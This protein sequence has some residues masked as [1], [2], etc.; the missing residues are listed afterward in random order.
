[1]RHHHPHP[2]TN[3]DVDLRRFRMRDPGPGAFGAFGPGARPGGRG[4]R[5]FGPG[6]DPAPDEPLQQGHHGGTGHHD[7]RG[8]GFGGPRGRGRAGRGD[9]RAA[10]LL[11]LAEQPMHGYQLIQEIAQRSED[12]WRPS[13]GAVYPALAM[14]EDEGLVTLSAEGGRRLARLTDAGAAYVEENAATLGVPW[15]DAAERPVNPARALRGAL[16]ALSAAAVQVART[17]T[18]QQ[19]EQALAVIE[20]ARRDLYLLLAG[21]APVAASAPAAQPDVDPAQGVG[22]TADVDEEPTA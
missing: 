12:R 10:V 4:P 5:G 13:P 19:A 8:R 18:P 1:M 2:R 16:E 15:Q 22:R 7:H 3:P 6:G 17:G 14:L 21:E 9:I 20:R 11:L